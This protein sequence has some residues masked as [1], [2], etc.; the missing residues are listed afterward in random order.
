MKKRIVA[1]CLSVALVIGMVPVLSGCT[2]RSDTL[3]IMTWAYFLDR[4]IVEDFR[5]WYAEEHGRNLRVRIQ[6]F[7]TN[8]EVYRSLRDGDDFDVINPSDYMV[9]RL[10]VNN[11]LQQLDANV[12]DRFQEVGYDMLIDLTRIYDPYS[13][14]S[15][16]YIWGTYGIMY[17][18]RRANIIENRDAL[19]TWGALFSNAAFDNQ[20]T[21]KQSIRDTYG[22]AVLYLYRDRL[23]EYSNNFT[24]YTTDPRYRALLEDLFQNFS[25]EVMDGPQGRYARVRNLLAARHSTIHSYEIDEGKSQMLAGGSAAPALGLYWSVD[26]GWAMQQTNGNHLGYIIPEE[27]TNVWV[28]AWIIPT[29]AVNTSAANAWIYFNLKPEIAIRNARF[30]G[31]QAA[32]H[33]AMQTLRAEFE[34]EITAGT[35]MFANIPANNPDFAATFMEAVFPSEETLQRSAVMGDPGEWFIRLSNMFAEVRAGAG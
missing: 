4:S 19:N 24:D 11:L 9:E 31:G 12:R 5:E 1:L 15:V 26:A 10:R 17:D 25:D 28:D 14:Y 3:V 21:L 18:T 2:S 33:Q 7:G 27:G 32:N 34:A 20:V 22:A 30:A 29:T 23:A 8:E 13:L 16:P 35:G 6:E